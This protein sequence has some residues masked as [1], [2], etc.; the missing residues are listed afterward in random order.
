MLCLYFQSWFHSLERVHCM[1]LDQ[2]VFSSLSLGE[3][4]EDKWIL[5]LVEIQWSLLK[6]YGVNCEAKWSNYKSFSYTVRL[7]WL[8][9]DNVWL[10]HVYT[11]YPEHQLFFCMIVGYNSNDLPLCSLCTGDLKNKS[12]NKLCLNSPYIHAINYIS[13]F[14]III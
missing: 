5:H 8:S 6:Q 10:S 3:F 13:E 1:F 2:G 4:W 14:L 12:L 7:L 9:T 11:L